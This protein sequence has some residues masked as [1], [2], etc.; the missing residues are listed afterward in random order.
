MAIA[1]ILSAF[2]IALSVA[3][4][5]VAGSAVPAPANMTMTD[6]GD[7]DCCPKAVQPCGM[8][9]DRCPS[10]AACALPAFFPAPSEHQ[11]M[12]PRFAAAPLMAPF[13]EIAPSHTGG[14]PLRPPR[15]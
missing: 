5:P 13:G 4:A 2:L 1:R 14:P 9:K 8:T 10:V 11:I 3:L 12:L 7:N 6:G 15:V